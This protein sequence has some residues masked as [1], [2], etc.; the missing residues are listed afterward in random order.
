M[1]ARLRKKEMD[2]SRRIASFVADY[3]TYGFVDQ[4]ETGETFAEGIERLAHATYVLME[5]GD[6]DSI[7]SWIEEDSIDH[8]P[9]MLQ[10]LR[11]M[12]G[13]LD[14]IKELR[15]KTILRNAS[16]KRKGMIICN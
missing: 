9:M 7:L 8:D 4:M 1:S 15:G 2:L 14:E 10:E 3:D 6:F 13:E 11:A 5:E 16:M 12:R